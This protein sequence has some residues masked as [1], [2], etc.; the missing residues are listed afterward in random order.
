MPHFNTCLITGASSGI[1]KELAFFL[2]GI[3]HL[4]LSGRNESALKD[5]QAQLQSQ[6]EIF[7]ADLSQKEQRK[8]LS[9]WAIDADLVI[10]SAGFGSYG[11]ADKQPLEEQI[12]MIEV[13]ATAVSEFTLFFLKQWKERQTKGTI[14]NISSIISLVPFWGMSVYA[15][16]KRFVRDLS[17]CLDH[18]A[19]RFACR[20]LCSC[21]GPV[22]TSFW[23]TASKG[24]TEQN[25]KYIAID[26]K[27]L[28]KRI[29]KQIQNG[30]TVDNYPFYFTIAYYLTLPFPKK[31]KAY[32]L[33]KSI[34]QRYHTYD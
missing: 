28:V 9:Q 1:G 10:N 23:K 14:L 25:Q 3:T 12:K 31:I 2:D 4:K 22:K 16:T 20:V 26:P 33:W 7:V 21:P 34:K 13:N 29:W 24:Q 11:W 27:R 6:S 8:A 15:A 17:W 5:V 18:E 30:K 32:F 19:K